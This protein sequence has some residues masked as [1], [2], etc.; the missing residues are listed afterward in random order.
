MA[1]KRPFEANNKSLKAL[2]ESARIEAPPSFRHMKDLEVD[3]TYKVE[4]FVKQSTQHSPQLVL[5][6]IED[7]TDS[8]GD[9]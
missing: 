9:I 7:V 3:K 6:L 5:K 2:N 1:S 8:D 4:E